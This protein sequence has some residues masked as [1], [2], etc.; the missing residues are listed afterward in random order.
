MR[1]VFDLTVSTSA[2]FQARTMLG[3]LAADL[4]PETL[5]DLRIVVSE[6]VSN[7]V[8][9]GP[10]TPIHV[11]LEA[12]HA[13]A[14]AARSSTTASRRARRASMSVPAP[15]A[16]TACAWSTASPRRGVSAR[17]AR[18]SG[19]NSGDEREVYTPKPAVGVAQLVERLVVVQVVA[20]SSPVA[21]P[22]WK[23]RKRGV[24]AFPAAR[25][26]AGQG[27]IRGLTLL[28]NA[29]LAADQGSVWSKSSEGLTVTVSAFS[30]RLVAI[31]PRASRGPSRHAGSRGSSGRGAT[32]S[33]RSSLNAST[34]SVLIVPQRCP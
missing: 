24:S 30:P 21:H 34:S 9:Y 29:T 6:L 2:P 4:D 31:Q 12:R 14:S 20:G 15:T 7:A 26:L 3:A 5:G 1:L 28:H 13:P 11:E 22:S 25:R 18:T 32:R 8:K 17:A 10:G 23:P 27:S 19:S 33:S 16:A